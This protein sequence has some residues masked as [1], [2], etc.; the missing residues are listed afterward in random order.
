MGIPKTTTVLYTYMYISIQT[1]SD[2]KTMAA[3]MAI[4]HNQEKH[5][6]AGNLPP[7]VMEMLHSYLPLITL[8]FKAIRM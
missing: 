6:I 8:I 2:T 1:Q 7:I 5:T 3:V 4:K